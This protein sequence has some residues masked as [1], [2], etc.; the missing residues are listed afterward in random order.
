MSKNCTCWVISLNPASE[1]TQKLIADLA[2]QG[3]NAE[4]FPAVDGRAGMPSLEGDERFLD[5]LAMVRH[6]KHLTASE[7]GCYLSHLRA[8]KQAYDEGYQHIC[9]MEEDVVIEPLFGDV[10]RSVLDKELDMVR[11][12][13]LRIRKRVV[14][15]KLVGEHRLVRPVRGGLGAQ[16]YVLNRAGMKKLFTYGQKIYEP[17]DKVMDHF[18]LFDLQVF[19]VEPHVAHELVHETSVQKAADTN[20]ETP[21]LWHRL[22]FH[23]VKLW[24]SLRRHF[25]RFCHRGD[26]SGA[27]LPSKKVGRTERVH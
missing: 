5:D 6:G 17:I 19:A 20:D 12:M 25:Y 14:L 1:N 11:M 8:A 24:F 7:L 22:A 9:L 27:T 3:L 4:I 18:F 15:D 16:A 2:A 21:R 23:P 26:F 13:S 10:Y